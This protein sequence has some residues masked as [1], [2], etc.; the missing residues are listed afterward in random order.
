MKQ[1]DI[2]I[3]YRRSSYD[4]ANL[5]ATR[6]KSAGYSVF[7][8]METLRSGKFN[9]QLY[10]VIDNCKDFIVVLP[11]NS[12][13]RCVNE[14]DWVRLEV[15]RA[16][17]GN[18]NIIPIMLNGFEWPDTMPKGMEE[19]CYY[20]ALTASSV[21]YF[22]LAMERLQQQFLHSK[23][24]MPFARVAKVCAIVGLT[25]I[26]LLGVLWGLFLF[27]SK[28]V[29]EKYANTI[30]GS[31]EQCHVIM[32]ENK[33]LRKKWTDFH[34]AFKFDLNAERLA[35]LQQDMRS[36]LEF[37]E[38]SI[39]PLS[40]VDADMLQISVYHSFLL[41]L[42]GINSQEIAV[43]P[44]M[45]NMNLEEFVTLLNMAK[46]TVDTPNELYLRQVAVF[47]EAMEYSLNGYYAA[48]LAAISN[49]PKS[50][51]ELY[52]Q[53]STA[54]TSYPI[55]YKI[56]EDE[57]YYLDIMNRENRKAEEALAAYRNYIETYD[58]QLDSI[59]RVVQQL[60]QQCEESN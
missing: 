49:F 1:Y 47:L 31:A 29:C 4:T 20:H 5:I 10:E 52:N 41:A 60:L 42:H 25:L 24:R 11:P 30:T 7:F 56:D 32:K 16:M 27:L 26:A 9:V 19:L 53:L 57:E 59:D 40:N 6:L 28:D 48:V 21:E 46:S 13:D 43:A 12:L 45:I 2:F 23:R 54:W 50:S 55:E 34:T 22:D 51:R 39:Q 58:A 8:D 38:K 37:T 36:Y 15:C 44:V 3:S 35:V 18:K 33:R 14:E 17:A